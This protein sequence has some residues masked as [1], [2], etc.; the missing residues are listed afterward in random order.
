MVAISIFQFAGK[1]PP[2]QHDVSTRRQVINANSERSH[3]RLLMDVLC[4]LS[5]TSI[6]K[7]D[8]FGCRRPKLEAI[9]MVYHISGLW[10]IWIVNQ[11]RDYWHVFP[12]SVLFL[13]EGCV[14]S[15]CIAV[16]VLMI[17]IFV[18]FALGHPQKHQIWNEHGTKG[19]RISLESLHIR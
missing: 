12:V 8:R 17:S 4:S 10:K 19:R 18:E 11:E 14:Y 2:P 6:L 16:H 7:W 9:R 3:W 15:V 1:I 5:N 13:V